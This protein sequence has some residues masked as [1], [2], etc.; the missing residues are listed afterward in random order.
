MIRNAVIFLLLVMATMS[1][2]GQRHERH[3]TLTLAQW[4]AAI[5]RVPVL[6][7]QSQ[8]QIIVPHQ[9]PL[10]FQV[11]F[12]LK[13]TVGPKTFE[14]CMFMNTGMGLVG[15]LPPS[16]SGLINMI[17]PEIQEFN[18]SVISLKGNVYRYFNKKGRRDA[19]DH[20]VST[21]NTQTFQYQQA[22]NLLSDTVALYRKTEAGTYCN[23][24]MTARAYRLQNGGPTWFIYGDRFPEKLHPKKYMGNYGV[25]Y[26]YTAEGLFIITE[27]RADSYQ[28]KVTDIQNSNA[29]LNATPFQLLEDKFN[30]DR[31]ADVQKEQEKLDRQAGGISGDCQAEKTA[32]LNFRREVQRKQEE[33][34]RRSKEGNMY[35]DAGAQKAML[36]MM[37]PL[38]SVQ[39]GIINARL[40]IC[41]AQKGIEHSSGSDH[42]RAEEKI[43]CLNRQMVA[44][45]QA[46]T[47]MRALD[48]RYASEPGRAYAEKSRVYMAVLREQHC[49]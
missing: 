12:D 38:V 26:L 36:G 37:D 8:P 39:E 7:G 46:E 13:A 28:C 47:A 31:A 14:Q 49:D 42:A 40:S 10:C 11:E 33:N 25:G 44:L 4:K 34:L 21:G 18:F 20:F 41:L 9:S 19:L 5:T 1:V 45:Q 2:F 6:T 48:T 35:Q 27:F 29:C 15:L 3:D 24:N 32:L 30:T 43:G 16:T 22:S 17:M 23:G